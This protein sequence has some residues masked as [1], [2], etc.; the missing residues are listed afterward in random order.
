MGFGSE[1]ASNSQPTF[2]FGWEMQVTSG[3][4]CR[5]S[6]VAIRAGLN[7]KRQ[8][9]R[10]YFSCMM[11]L[12]GLNGCREKT[13]IRLYTWHLTMILQVFASEARSGCLLARVLYCAHYR[14]LLT[15]THPHQH[16]A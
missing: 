7:R 6:G 5:R 1:T 10:K 13:K 8:D 2:E 3:A 15:T 9:R 14:L 12:G 16:S 4:A 11:V